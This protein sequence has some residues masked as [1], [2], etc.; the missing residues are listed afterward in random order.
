MEN[1][2]LQTFASKIPEGHQ[3]PIA[4]SAAVPIW[5]MQLQ[6]LPMDEISERAKACLDVIQ[7]VGEAILYR[8]PGKTARGFNALAEGI[9]C[10]SFF[11]GGVTCFGQK[12]EAKLD[13]S[14][15]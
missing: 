8:I 11:P 15:A 2:T 7:E 5:Q 9:A 3:L 14:S 12:F 13:C 10:L 4:L 6:G 1:P